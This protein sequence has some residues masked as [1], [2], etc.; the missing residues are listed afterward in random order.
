M[1]FNCEN[2]GTRYTLS[3]E[4]V[5]NRVL[6]IRCKV[7]EDVIIVRDP[8]HAASRP[9]SLAPAPVAEVEWY[10]SRDG[11]SPEGP[12]PLERLVDRIKRS[13]LE[14][15]D[16]VWNQSMTAW[17]RAEVALDAE[18]KAARATVP[19]PPIPKLPRPPG[20]IAEPAPLLPRPAR[21]AVKTPAPLAAKPP[22]TPAEA[23]VAPK[24][25]RSDP[26]AKPPAQEPAREPARAP[27]D[28]PE[29]PAEALQRAPAPELS[30]AAPDVAASAPPTPI[31]PP[32]T[33]TDDLDEPTQ[34][35]AADLGALF[36]S[37]GAGK[38]ANAEPAHDTVALPA[39]D[40][41]ADTLFAPA[42]TASA[43]ASMQSGDTTLLPE[44]DAPAPPAVA[45]WA[46]VAP[47]SADG[48]E[49]RLS[50]AGPALPSS[51]P[52]P[53]VPEPEDESPIAPVTPAGKASIT[54]TGEQFALAEDAFF[55]T[56][57]R[58]AVVSAAVSTPE[59]AD[60]DGGRSKLPLLIVLGVLLLGGGIALGLMFAGDNGGVAPGTVASS[61]APETDAPVSVAA[62]SE[63]PVSQPTSEAPVSEAPASEAPI[64]E[65]PKSVASAAPVTKARKRSVASRAKPKTVK[66]AA[67][68]SKA[69]ATSTG[70]F[71]AL[72][73][74]KPKDVAVASLQT[75]APIELPETL[76]PGK[77]SSIIRR[78]KK[79]LHGCYQRQ[80]KRDA[81]MRKANLKLAFNIERSGRTSNI[82]IDRK[83]DGT[84]LKSCLNRLVRRWRF[85]QF[86][87][88]AI[89]VEYPLFFQ[90][91]L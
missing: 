75:D 10:V 62:A 51:E 30:D 41:Q 16:M 50:D 59:Y 13:A 38:D 81:S 71:A 3:D 31:D 11:G 65:A 17:A 45:D 5:K 32:E 70:R 1:K 73:S 54:M 88:E 21:K 82:K 68:A 56:D 85:P 20:R 39:S 29:A 44:L 37:L 14:P 69:P 57:E 80:L 72:G 28:T 4:K 74:K 9:P 87:G 89:P 67:P 66:T 19:R 34:A 8:A 84:E 25:P 77:I 48:A 12:M 83:Y 43:A 24:V 58:P 61:A 63:A 15:T 47:E 52:P 49:A 78:Y 46:G 7:C 40:A 55:G 64:S 53:V 91:S 26:P 23:Q 6:K 18:F 2:C 42:A 22:A 27:S 60:D 36:A 79:G 76:S 33:P 35:M 90:A 86:T